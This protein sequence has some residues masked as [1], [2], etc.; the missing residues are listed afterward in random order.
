MENNKLKIIGLKIDGARKLTAFEMNNLKERGL[1][2]II[3]G[4]RQGKST[5]FDCLRLLIKKGESVPKDFVQHGKEKAEI[6]GKIGNYTI[7]E[8]IQDGKTPTFTVKD[9]KGM[10]PSN[11][12]S[13]VNDL[14]N[15]LTF[16]PRPFVDKTAIEK[17][18]FMCDVFQVDFTEIDNEIHSLET[19]RTLKGREVKAIGELVSVP[20]TDPIDISNVVKFNDE[21]KE[22]EKQI[23][24]ANDRLQT[25]DT[26]KTLLEC[27]IQ[28]LQEQLTQKESELAMTVQNIE[29]GKKYIETLPKPRPLQDIT[30][31]TA[32]NQ[33][34]VAYQEYLKKKADK[35]I[36]ENEYR[37][38]TKAIEHLRA[39]KL[40][41]LTEIKIPVPGLE[42]RED[43]IFHDGTH[44]ENWSDEQS[45]TI[46]SQLCL[47]M[48][49]KLKAVFIDQGETYDTNS[50]KQLE[51]WAIE[52][53]I[54]AFIT[55]VDDIPDSKE[56]DTFY[57]IEGQLVK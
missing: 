31:A 8:T 10:S 20:K 13:F 50:L 36:K 15:E 45:V 2:K 52:S 46:S 1:I 53:D 43:G 32:Q 18:R 5:V 55:I 11:P 17:W 23:E 44:C 26:T 57:I 38:Y 49:P 47:A 35:E 7:S 51:K 16:D 22:N 12:K 41:K 25:L 33:K 42:I 3:G 34:A 21:Q 14:I 39:E 48:N 40:K 28:D 37:E 56:D 19:E 24:K 6:V 9:D 29:K 30:E 4:N 54:Q 27:E